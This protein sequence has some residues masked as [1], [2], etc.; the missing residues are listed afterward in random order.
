MQ[1]QFLLP[2]AL[3]AASLSVSALAD[4]RLAPVVVTAS[5]TQQSLDKT[6]AA[7]SVLTREDIE[8]SQARSLHELLAG[9]PGIQLTNSGGY[10]KPSGIHIRGTNSSHVAVLMDGLRIGSATTGTVALEDLPLHAIERIEIVRGPV[11]SL[12]GADAVGGVIQIFTRQGGT[13]NQWHATA[14]AGS[15]NTRRA[16]GSFSGRQEQ[17]RYALDAG[18]FTTR[19]FNSTT[20]GNPDRNGYQR[21]SVHA[22]V[23]HAFADDHGIGFS[24]LHSRG[25]NA[26]DNVF[27]I[28]NKHRDKTWQQNISAHW[29]ID[30]SPLWHSRL[31][32]GE[33]R[34][35]SRNYLD[36][37]AGDQF[38]T[39]RRQISWQH[40]IQASEALLLSLGAERQHERIDTTFRYQQ[41]SRHNTGLFAQGLLKLG[42]QDWQFGLRHDDNNSYG[43]HTT[44]NLAWGYQLQQGPRLIA[45][46]G[47]AFKAPGFNDLYYPFMGNPDLQAE[48][49]SSSELGLQD[50]FAG[51]YWQLRLY[52]T[53]IR[54]LI[55][56]APDNA[57]NWLPANVNRAR[58]HGLEFDLQSRLGNWQ[59]G[60]T[61]NLTDTKDR[62]TGK[63]LIYRARETARLSLARDFGRWHA[64][65][66]W[67][68]SS[69]RYNDEANTQKLAGHGLLNATLHHDLD[70]HWHLA[71]RLDNLLDKSWQEVL[72]Y[73]TPGR[74]V[75]VSVN[76]HH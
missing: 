16:S 71:V 19:G 13:A 39:R 50:H 49:S 60:M 65:M 58:I 21:S 62:E 4:P 20:D 25:N 17:T 51:G 27:A 11:S 54:N 53:R 55:A 38:N 72:G 69:S 41:N 3:L 32:V 74:T 47:T 43:S 31:L 10:G 28:L 26:Y 14:G 35:D 9:M 52:Q 56:W 2:V 5:R 44:G 22:R 15:H 30:L 61:F 33:S 6:L 34:D 23:D 75:F 46:H 37:L 12:Y 8:H 29:D 70:R 63:E 18:R 66:E 42:Q 68:A 76:Y 57:G 1:N 67:L 7:T 64:G 36:G 48:K 24:L 40:D 73:N 45:S 59:L